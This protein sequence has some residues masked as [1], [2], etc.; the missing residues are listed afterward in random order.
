MVSKIMQFESFYTH[1]PTSKYINCFAFIHRLYKI[2]DV[3][4]INKYLCS[5]N[6]HQFARMH[7]NA[8]F[9]IGKIKNN[10]PSS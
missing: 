4:K 9:V 3:E 6:F 2:L 1:K 8:S 10:L 5:V 7:K